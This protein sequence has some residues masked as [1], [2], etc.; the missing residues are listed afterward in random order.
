MKLL[1]HVLIGVGSALLSL[2]IFSGCTIKATTDTATDGTTEFLSSTSGQAWWTQDGLVREGQHAHAFVANNYDNL[3][4]EIA[5]GEGEYLQALATV[6]GVAPT[7]QRRF[8]QVLQNQYAE[9]Q[10]AP[11][12]NS[13]QSGDAVLRRIQSLRTYWISVEGAYDGSGS[14]N[15]SLHLSL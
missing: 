12:G 8:V 10:A 15:N 6:I 7:N 3:L 5:K 4:Q 14:L 11:L 2:L 1:L 9:L 13:D